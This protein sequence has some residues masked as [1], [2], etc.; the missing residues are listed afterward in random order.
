VGRSIPIMGTRKSKRTSGGTGLADALFSQT[1]QRVLGLIFGQPERAFGTMELIELADSGRGTVQ[2][3]LAR[4]ESA[5][6][7][8]ATDGRAKRY[9]A[10]QASPIFSELR[11]LVDKTSGIPRVLADAL[12]PL[13][14][15][16]R[17]AIL[18]GSIAKQSD[19]ASSDIDLLIVADD[20]GLEDLFRTL[21][22][23]EERLGRRVNPTLYTSEEF[24]KRR[25]ASH[26]F[27]S[28]VM[29]GKYVVLLGSEDA[30]HPAR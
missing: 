21:A 10:N 12:A 14:P 16:I 20:I 17:L 4:L 23:A 8:S 6:L 18:F 13:A 27:L 30:V 22:P 1:Q 19:T 2:R 5:G 11:G 26:P 3:E 9:Q 24:R 7:I 28:K 25:R 15:S 29:Q